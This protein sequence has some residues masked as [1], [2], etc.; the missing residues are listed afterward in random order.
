M[1]VLK[2]YPL[3]NRVSPNGDGEQNYFYSGTNRAR[4]EQAIVRLDPTFSSAHRLTVRYTHDWVAR[5]SL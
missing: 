2:A 1:Q 3:P 4:T 5:E